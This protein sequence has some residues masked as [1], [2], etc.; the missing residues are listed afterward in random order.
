[1]RRSDEHGVAR[2]AADQ[3]DASKNE[4][5][6]QDFAEL[7]VVLDQRHHLIAIQLEEFAGVAGAQPEQRAAAG[8]HVDLAAELSRA[9]E[10]DQDLAFA[11]AP[12][13]L[14]RP[15][16][17]DE[18]RHDVVACLDEHFTRLNR[19][20]MSMR[21]DARDLSRGQCWKDVIRPCSAQWDQ[22]RALGHAPSY[23]W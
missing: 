12:D 9:V 13:N 2:P 16:C 15:G 17:Y 7:G 19:A 4:R 10:R 20:A 23:S 6:H 21:C 14:D 11:A 8:D 5:P 1:M 3:L 18:E 22:W